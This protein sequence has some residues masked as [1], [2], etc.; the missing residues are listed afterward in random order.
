MTLVLYQQ[1][2]ASKRRPVC[3][4]TQYFPGFAR[5]GPVSNSLRRDVSTN[6][7][8][9]R[10]GCFF[11]LW[12]ADSPKSQSLV[13]LGLW[14]SLELH[15]PDENWKTKMTSRLY[16]AR[17]KREFWSL[18]SITGRSC[19]LTLGRF[20]FPSPKISLVFR[21]AKVRKSRFFSTS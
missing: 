14:K 17:Q 3:V 8:A 1:A 18:F 7:G 2:D 19:P 5:L 12:Q 16:P 6:P 13:T 21:I 20:E 15:N 9:N 4:S 10:L 11:C